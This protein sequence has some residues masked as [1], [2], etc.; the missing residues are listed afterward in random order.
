M[1]LVVE[2]L[3]KNLQSF[4]FFIQQVDLCLRSCQLRSTLLIHALQFR[5]MALAVLLEQLLLLQ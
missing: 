2:L 4:D 3:Q 1:C 5:G